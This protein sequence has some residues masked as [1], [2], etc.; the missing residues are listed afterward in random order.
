M[1][2]PL[3]LLR[4]LPFLSLLHLSV[5]TNFIVILA[6]DLGVNDINYNYNDWSSPFP[7]GNTPNLQKMAKEGM[8]LNRTYTQPVCAPSRA[9]LQTGLYTTHRRHGVIRNRKEATE[10]DHYQVLESRDFVKPGVRTFAEVLRDHGYQTAHFGK[11]RTLKFIDPT[12]DDFPLNSGYDVFYESGSPATK[13]GYTKL[14]SMSDPYLGS[15]TEPYTSGEISHI[16]RFQ[17]HYTEAELMTL[18]LGQN[19]HLTDALEKAVED[20]ITS[21]TKKNK[22][23]LVYWAPHAPHGPYKPRQDLKALYPDMPRQGLV[24]GLDQAIGRLFDFLTSQELSQDTLVL[25]M[26][27]N[28]AACNYESD[29]LTGCKGKYYDGG[30]R[31]ASLA[32]QPG[33]IAAGSVNQQLI[34]VTDVFATLLD[35]AGVTDGPTIDGMSFKNLLYDTGAPL[36]KRVFYH[37]PHLAS[38]KS[39]SSAYDPKYKIMWNY[40]SKTWALYKINSVNHETEET[41]ID[42]S[43]LT[44]S[45]KNRVRNLCNDLLVYLTDTRSVPRNWLIDKSTNDLVPLPSCNTFQ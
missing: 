36:R 45:A 26:S 44:D 24:E 27:D 10:D 23:F 21:F 33:K 37:E 14:N 6:D 2:R 31:S 15:Y 17:T 13:W 18:L 34:H 38:E 25:F 22:P 28:G 9:C 30:V 19:K 1:L 8:L 35:I 32:W 40:I 11:Y 43:S 29:S 20:T 7:V 39:F 3:R 41:E 5:A 42:F 12:A 4:L 16:A